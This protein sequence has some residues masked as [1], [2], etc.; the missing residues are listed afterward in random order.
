MLDNQT[1][2]EKQMQKFIT[3]HDNDGDP[4]HINQFSIIAVTIVIQK[5]NETDFFN[6]CIFLGGSNF[7]ARETQKEVMETI[8]KAEQKD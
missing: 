4:I 3:L 8:K 5:I 1:N 2:Q 7:Y 6:S